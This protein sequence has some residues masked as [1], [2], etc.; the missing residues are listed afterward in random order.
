MYVAT[1]ARRKYIAKAKRIVRQLAKPTPKRKRSK[2]RA[3]K[4][5]SSFVR[6]G[7]SIQPLAS[8]ATLT[9]CDNDFSLTSTAGVYARDTYRINSMYDPDAT[10]GGNQP[11]GF[12]IMMGLYDHYQ[13]LSASIVVTITHCDQRSVI[14]INTSDRNTPLINL[15]TLRIFQEN[16]GS[17]Y[18]YIIKSDDNRGA[19][20]LKTKTDLPKFFG[21]PRKSFIGSSRFIGQSTTNPDD[22]AAYHV[23]LWGLNS[24]TSTIRYSVRM[25]FNCLFSEPKSIDGS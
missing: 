18:K 23:M 2:Y 24:A 17:K 16:P 20:V 21:I 1:P 19:V 5:R 6:L 15:E 12:D 11:N 8:L 3:A 13:V 10:G 14:G 22:P 7:K 25:E 9:Y 4:R